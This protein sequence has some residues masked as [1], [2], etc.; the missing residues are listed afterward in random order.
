M[1]RLTREELEYL[2]RIDRARMEADERGDFFDEDE[3]LRREIRSREF[4]RILSSDDFGAEGENPQEEEDWEGEPY[5]EQD[6]ETENPEKWAA[7]RPEPEEILDPWTEDELR[8]AA[9]RGS[10]SSSGRGLRDAEASYADFYDFAH[11]APEDGHGIT[12]LPAVDGNRRKTEDYFPVPR[13]AEQQH[14]RDMETLSRECRKNEALLDHSDS[15]EGLGHTDYSDF[16]EDLVCQSEDRILNYLDEGKEE[17]HYR[18]LNE[19]RYTGGDEYRN[20][21]EYQ[22]HGLYRDLGHWLEFNENA[23]SSD[24]VEKNNAVKHLRHA[25]KA[26]E[27][28]E[29]R[30]KEV[31]KEKEE[32]KERFEDGEISEL[33]Y[34]YK[35]AELDNDLVLQILRREFARNTGGSSVGQEIGNIMDRQNNL[36]DDMEAADPDILQEARDFI[37][38]VP[39]EAAEKYIDDAVEEGLLPRTQ[40]DHL[41]LLATRPV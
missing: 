15:D 37:G 27:K 13:T 22:R 40:A 30:H 2:E 11:T 28:A 14:E 6:S 8:H 9:R 39:R 25:L 16:E 7:E 17:E 10:D 23:D 21:Y 38:S 4:E 18:L 1:R 35:V 19:Q 41:L 12:P 36:L 26:V 29:A 5:E 24:P 31:Q 20:G 3:N 33:D 34:G 32:W